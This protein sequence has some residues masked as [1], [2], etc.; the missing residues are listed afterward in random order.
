MAFFF[1]HG[2]YTVMRGQGR[3]KVF[4]VWLARR[5]G[6]YLLGP[7]VRLYE[8]FVVDVEGSATFS[9][10]CGLR[11]A[12]EIGPSVCKKRRLCL[13]EGEAGG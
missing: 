2:L 1:P 3:W 10:R 12:G 6:G 8:E 7:G 13:V 5:L 4:W 11:A 9:S